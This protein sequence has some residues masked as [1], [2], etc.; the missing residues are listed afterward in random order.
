MTALIRFARR[1]YTAAILSALKEVDC[2]DLP[3]GG[4][5]VLG[6]MV[7]SHLP[8]AKIASQLG[9]P[10]EKV[11][12]LVDSLFERGYIELEQGTAS[13]T[14]RGKLALETSQK[15]IEK[16]EAELLEKVSPEYL[17]HTRATLTALIDIHDRHHNLPRG[18]R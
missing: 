17:E 15:T 12:R 3:R 2:A 4:M 9:F 10:K 7:R 8:P 5:Y 11:S 18:R 14:E 6:S 13:L 1:T 16:L